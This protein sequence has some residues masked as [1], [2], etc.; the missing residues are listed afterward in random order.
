MVLLLRSEVVLD[1]ERLPDLLGGL[2]LDHVGN[3]LAANI[4]ESLDVEIVGGLRDGVSRS[5]EFM[6]RPSPE[7]G[8]LKVASCWTYQDDLKEHLLVDLHELL[9]P[10]FNIG[11][12]ASVVVVIGG[13][14]GV[15]LVVL[16]P[17]DDLLQDGLVDL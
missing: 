4:K 14:L 2:A 3:S 7:Y 12:L 8:S 1:V 9:I 11:G 10:L 13:A 17:L 16:A 5:S 15:V 6:L